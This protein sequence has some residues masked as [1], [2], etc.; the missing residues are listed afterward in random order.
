MGIG[1][2]PDVR[3]WA[4]DS[5]SPSACRKQV[6]EGYHVDAVEP[7]PGV[8]VPSGGETWTSVAWGM[9]LIGGGGVS[10]V[11]SPAICLTWYF[12][13]VGNLKFSFGHA[14]LLFRSEA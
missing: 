9:G 5:T 6:L 12:W 13:F 3:M 8:D 10:P 4:Q 11:C 2:G 7:S 14:F 1:S